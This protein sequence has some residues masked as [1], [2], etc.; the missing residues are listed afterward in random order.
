[1]EV[2]LVLGCTNVTHQELVYCEME[3]L[4]CLRYFSKG[5]SYIK[6]RLKDSLLMTV[7]VV[8]RR[9]VPLDS[10]TSCDAGVGEECAPTRLVQ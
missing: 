10:S 1:M 7:V 4:I 9:H 3:K 5:K 6:Q 2:D 8:S